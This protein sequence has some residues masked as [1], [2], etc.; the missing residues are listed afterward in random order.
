M[1]PLMETY[2]QMPKAQ[3][4]GLLSRDYNELFGIE[5]KIYASWIMETKCGCSQEKPILEGKIILT[6]AHIKNEME[7]KT[8]EITKKI[9]QKSDVLILRNL[10][11]LQ[12][13]YRKEEQHAHD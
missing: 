10:S 8:R 4:L 3:L 12:R 11:R 1:N 13:I 7:E 6:C 5:R 2:F 9:N